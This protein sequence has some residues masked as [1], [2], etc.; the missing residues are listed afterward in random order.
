M[1]DV[2]RRTFIGTTVGTALAMTAHA[3]ADY[4]IIDSH[5]H[6]WRHDPEFPFAPGV[7]P[8]RDAAPETVLELM[9]ANG[10]SKTVLIQMIHYKY[11]NRFLLHVLKQYPGTFRGVCRVDPLDAAAP[12]QLSKLTEQG[13]H[14]VRLSPGRGETGDWIAG[15]LMP[16]LWKRCHELKVPMTVL[17]PIGRMPQVAQLMEALPDLTLVIDHM[18]DCPVDQPEELEKLI[19]LKR[20]P[21]VFVKVSHTWSL[22][23]QPYPW[24]DSQELVKRLHAAFGPQRLMWGTDWPI[25]EGKAQY[26]QALT[27]VRDDMKFLNADDK[28]W[29]LSKT[30]ERVW[31]FPA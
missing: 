12:D 19:A 21:N 10:V 4:R 17:A 20:F 7:N 26:S 24:L 16:P 5:V 30:I 18:A 29:M 2:S 27:V 3:A 22:S 15:P 6:T 28:S 9:K 25:I 31:P 8:N 11:D 1:S 14:G 23:H 13:T